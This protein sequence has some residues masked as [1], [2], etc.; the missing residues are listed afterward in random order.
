LQKFFLMGRLALGAGRRLRIPH[1][2]R[3]FPHRMERV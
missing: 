3:T 2:R 1:R